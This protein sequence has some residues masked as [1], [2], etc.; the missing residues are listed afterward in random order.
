MIA[1]SY[2]FYNLVFIILSFFA[3][4]ASLLKILLARGSFHGERWG[5]YPPEVFQKLRRKP[6]IWFHAASVGEVRVAL[7]LLGEM[8]KVYPR[9]GFV[10]STTTPQGRALA[11]QAH[12]VDMAL[13]APLDQPWV[14]KKVVKL[15]SPRLLLVAETEL[16]PNLL[17]EVKQKGVPIILFNGRVSRRSYRLYRLLRFFF[18]DVLNNFDALCLKSSIDRDRMMHLGA[19]PSTI[20]VVGDIKFHQVFDAAEADS[21]RL[22]RDLRLSQ[23]ETILIAGSTHEGEEEIILQ[24]FKELQVD[25]PQLILILAPRHLQRIPRVEGL[26]ESQGVRWVRRTMLSEKRR[27]EKVIL[28]DTLGELAVLY[29]LGTAIFVGGSFGRVGGH[30]LL[31]VLAHGKGVIFGPNMENVREIAQLVVDGGVGI[32]VS[33]PDELKEAARRLIADPA[34]RKE[35]GVKSLALIHEQQGALERTMK[36]IKE[37]FTG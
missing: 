28:L 12:G 22:R 37:I 25:F 5:V 14:V 23:E 2:F 11:S 4:P 3:L 7:S 31:E 15:I 30:N 13:L 1:L 20:H 26:L 18:K 16:W 32:Q 34:L 33:T 17:K 35:M 10:I 6:I 19:S 24:V 8:K 27:P 36:I 9:H 29:G 21:K